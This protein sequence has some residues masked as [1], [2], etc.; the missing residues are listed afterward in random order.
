MDTA[1]VLERLHIIL[2]ACLF[3]VGVWAAV[4]AR[5][6]LK[7]ALGVAVAQAGAVSLI[8][9]TRPDAADYAV[10]ASILGGAVF[11]VAAAIAVALR[12]TYGLNEVDDVDS[13]DDLS[14]PEG[15]AP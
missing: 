13:I 6:F 11:V 15:P 4:G 10:A 3:G 5:P 9:A 7:R 1:V 14:R 12:E 2:A 8:V